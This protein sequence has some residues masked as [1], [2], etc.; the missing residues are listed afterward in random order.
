MARNMSCDCGCVKS[1]DNI[2][3]APEYCPRCGEPWSPQY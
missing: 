2:A 3:E 1:Y